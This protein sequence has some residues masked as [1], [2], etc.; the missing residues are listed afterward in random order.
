[1]SLSRAICRSIQALRAEI[2]KIHTEKLLLNPDYVTSEIKRIFFFLQ[3]LGLEYKS[4]RN[5]T[6]QQTDIVN[7]RDKAG[8]IT[9]VRPTFD[10][11]KNKAIEEKHRKGQLDKQLDPQVL[12][13]FALT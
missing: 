3:A 2:R 6:F 4:F 13:T 12:P 8:N 1:M 7:V 11:I 9:T 5:H 10:S